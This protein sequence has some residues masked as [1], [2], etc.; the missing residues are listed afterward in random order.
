MRKTLCG[1][2]LIAVACAPV[3]TVPQNENV[4][5]GPRLSA[6]RVSSGVIRLALDNGAF[7]AI[8]YNLCTSQLERRSASGWTAVPTNEVCTMQLMTLN[9]GRDATFEKRLPAGLAPGDY[10]YVTR[11]ENPL[12][13]SQQ[14]VATE[15]FSVR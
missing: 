8:G 14:I 12:G 6:E 1:I 5:T 13:G 11:V 2:L 10:H 7:Q 4:S 3:S 15:P 9:P